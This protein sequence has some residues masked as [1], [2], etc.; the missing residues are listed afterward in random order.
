MSTIQENNSRLNINNTNLTDILEAINTLPTLSLQEK[1]VTPTTEQQII[2]PDEGYQ[3]LSNVTV[4]AIQDDNLIAENIKDGVEILG[5]TGNFV[6][7]KY[8]PRKISFSGYTG[9]D[10]D[11]EIANLDTKNITNLSSTFS[12]CTY[13]TNADLSGWDVKNVTDLNRL[14]YNCNRLT[15]VN[16]SGWNTSKVTNM[17]YLFYSIWS[18]TELDV[19]MFDTSNV[20][21]MSYMFCMMS[22][23]TSLNLTN[24]NTSNVT[25][26]SYMFR[27]GNALTSLDVSSFNT[28]KVT[29]MAY[30]FH[31]CREL[32]TLDLSNFDVSKVTNMGNMFSECR[33][34]TKLIINN[35]NVFEL[36]QT[37]VFTNTPIAG[38]T[39]Y[40]NGELGYVYVPDDLVETYKNSSVWSTYA[41]QIKGISELPQE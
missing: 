11:Y 20:T 26:M 1:T 37:N 38:Y 22:V 29:N 25:N 28:S 39:D 21:D 3:G 6:G 41:S 16:F 8:A 18:V 24:F 19:S 40:T 33:K 30:M 15:T 4:E 36:K 13:F 10:L 7:G 9:S 34:L 27:S 31:S 32:T 17:S 14:F 2:T 23:L 35:P 12:G 5:V